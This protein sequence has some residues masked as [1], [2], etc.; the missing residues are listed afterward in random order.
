MM[1]YL[2][3]SGKMKKVPESDYTMYLPWAR[4]NAAN[5][6]YPC[7]IA[8][9]FQSGDI[10][11]NDGAE[12]ETVL[13]WHFCGFAY[14]TGAVSGRLLGEI[15]NEV[16]FRDRRRMLLITEDDRIVSFF[17]HADA[18]IGRRI[19]Y[20]YAGMAADRQT[21][22]EIE[23]AKIDSH[24]FRAISGNIVPAFSWKMTEFLKNGCGYAA[25]DRERYCGTAFSAAVSSEEIDIGVETD[26]EYRGRGI[27]SA[28][29]QRLCAEAV[30]QG[31]KPVWAHGETNAGSMHTAL[32][33]GFLQSRINA[34]IRVK[35]AGQR[36]SR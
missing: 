17:R 22:T 11:V 20:E 1:I 35:E 33:C 8:E 12:V 29:V 14:I 36:G 10:Y 27:A 21:Q 2:T 31:K 9:G 13:F 15:L 3:K 28:L 34:A 4:A 25:F 5:R 26:P 19:E 16:C 23:I 32:R 30:S 24:N 6:V 7:S 18:E